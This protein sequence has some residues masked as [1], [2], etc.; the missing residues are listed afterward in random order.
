M[1]LSPS[2]KY[3]MLRAQAEAKAAHAS[4]EPTPVPDEKPAKKKGLFD[5][6]GKKK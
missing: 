5:F 6:F 2:M 3:V 4:E 1:D